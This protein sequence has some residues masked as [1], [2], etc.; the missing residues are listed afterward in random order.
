MLFIITV[1]F[2][3]LGG[4][5][6]SG[7]TNDKYDEWPDFSPLGS[8]DNLYEPIVPKEAPPPPPGKGDNPDLKT[9]TYDPLSEKPVIVELPVTAEGYLEPVRTNKEPVKN[10]SN[11]SSKT[12]SSDVHKNNIKEK[13]PPS[14]SRSAVLASQPIYEEIN[15]N[16]K[17]QIDD[18]LDGDSM[19]TD[20]TELQNYMSRNVTVSPSSSFTESDTSSTSGSLN[21]PRPIPRK[22]PK[23]IDSSVFEQPYIAMNRPSIGMS[24]NESQL[25]ETVNLLTSAN[26]QTLREIYT[27][28][29]KEFKK[30]NVNFNVTGAAGPLKW[31][32]F[33]IY[34][35]P[36]HKSQRC[37]VYNAKLRS[38]QCSCQLMVMY[39][40]NLSFNLSGVMVSV[41]A[42]SAKV[43]G[44]IPS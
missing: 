36:V 19:K 26:L 7:S 29:E 20:V 4:S 2:L 17:D 12:E 41:L 27:H 37:I 15:G 30:D 6:S 8:L 10:N 22:R 32:D 13:S 16:E 40:I 3:F 39:R 31:R 24:L 44:L 1:K 25:R 21:R 43:V 38:N 18:D 9:H 33:D 34:G 35:K 28:Y 23:A 5:T 14:D 42:L 11:D